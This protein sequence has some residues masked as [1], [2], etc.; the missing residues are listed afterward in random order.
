MT[1]ATDADAPAPDAER[2]GHALERLEA[3]LRARTATGFDRARTDTGARSVR[4]PTARR[5]GA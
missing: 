3:A 4:T 2:L 1:R 5:D